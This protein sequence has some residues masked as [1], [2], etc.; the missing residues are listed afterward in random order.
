MEK[1]ILDEIIQ[2][3]ERSNL[4]QKQTIENLLSNNE[5]STAER[6]QLNEIRE[7]NK[8]IEEALKNKDLNKLQK[9]M[10]NVNSIIK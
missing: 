7:K 2:K 4:N 10:E 5:I 6:L 9:L 8:E 1:G 3:L